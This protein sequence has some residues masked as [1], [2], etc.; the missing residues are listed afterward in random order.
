MKIPTNWTFKSKE[1]ADNF[2]AHVREQLPWYD[3][4]TSIVQQCVKHYLPDNGTLYDIGAS[5][6]NIGRALKEIIS[7][8]KAKL[9]AVEPSKDMA[10]NYSGGGE[11]LVMDACDV[12][13]EEMDVAIMFLVLMFVPVAKRRKLLADVM[14]SIRPGGAL[15]IFD[16]LLPQAGYVSLIRSRLTLSC[17]LSAGATADEILT[18]ELSL[19]GVQ[20]PISTDELPKGCTTIFTFGDFA[21]FV[22]EKH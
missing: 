12:R 10:V 1:V 13:Y 17:K 18:K 19:S 8:R 4:A 16:K 22:C 15:V 14:A 5:N 11:L 7:T 3:L 20:R 9:Y 6:G 2:D 21:G